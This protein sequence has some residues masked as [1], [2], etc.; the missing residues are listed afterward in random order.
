MSTVYTTIESENLTEHLD[1]IKDLITKFEKWHDRLDPKTQACLK[2]LYES[3]RGNLDN[4]RADIAALT[5]EYLVC[6]AQQIV[7][8]EDKK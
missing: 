2:N 8:K 1:R 6:V 7:E 5:S 3:A 4:A